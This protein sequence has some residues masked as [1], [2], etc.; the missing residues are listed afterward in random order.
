VSVADRLAG[1][2]RAMADAERRAGRAPGSVRLVA[3]SKGQ[4][5]AAVSEAAAAGQRIFGENYAREMREK[6]LELT[7]S[8]LNL[9]WHFIGRVQAGNARDIATASLVHGVGSVD[10]AKALAKRA[11]GAAIP[12]LLQLSLW[13]EE[14]KNGFDLHEIERDLD[15]LRKLGGVAVRGFM[16]MPP[17]DAEP[18]AAFAA[19]RGVRDRLAPDLP[20]LSMG[21]SG[22]FE[23][24][25]L[26][27][28]TLVRVG[29]AIFGPRPKKEAV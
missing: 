10:Q 12:V 24:A 21:M 16:A 11:Q 26:E 25:I 19:V 28:A 20:E 14:S 7:P 8:M 18:R 4:P 3:A 29:T 15:V 27:G 2:L 13:A 9:E 1:V 17:P 6:R 23:E 5:A 22:D